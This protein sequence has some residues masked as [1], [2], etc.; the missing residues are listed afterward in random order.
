MP[1]RLVVADVAPELVR[2]K[3][4]W[5]MVVNGVGVVLSALISSGD[6][7]SSS[8]AVSIPFQAMCFT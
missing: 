5:L 3:L 2:A 6:T 4:S 7:S 8:L 1:K